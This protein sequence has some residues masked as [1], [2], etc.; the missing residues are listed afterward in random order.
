[1]K[2]LCYVY[3][4]TLIQMTYQDLR[5]SN[6]LQDVASSGFAI[7]VVFMTIECHNLSF[8]YK[9]KQMSIHKPKN[10]ESS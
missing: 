4:T 8:L 6:S 1:M 9:T 5:K 2:T 3:C 7:I 10:A